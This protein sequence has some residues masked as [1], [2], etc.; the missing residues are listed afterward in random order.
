LQLPASQAQRPWPQSSV[1]G[2]QFIVHMVSA[3]SGFWVA[4]TQVVG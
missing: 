1:P 4:G 2:A 3:Q